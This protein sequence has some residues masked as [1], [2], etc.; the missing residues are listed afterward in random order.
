[1]LIDTDNLRAA[2]EGHYRALYD[3]GDKSASDEFVKEMKK[4]S[5]IED[6]YTR[7]IH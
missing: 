4:V 5:E 7:V 3:K 6:M 1:M 2:L